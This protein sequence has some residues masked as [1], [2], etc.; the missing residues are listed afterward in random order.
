MRVTLAA[1]QLTVR[2][3]RV[4]HLL[5]VEYLRVLLLNVCYTYLPLSNFACCDSELSVRA[6]CN[7]SRNV[8]VMCVCFCVCVCLP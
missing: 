3:Q 6:C 1:A 7:G 4:L 5:A 8:T 2:A